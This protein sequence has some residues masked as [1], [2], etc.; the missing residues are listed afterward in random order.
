M[1]SINNIEIERKF[2]VNDSSYKTLA[3]GQVR[4]TQGYLCLNPNCSVRVR[5]W[6]EQAF[7][8]IK[9]KAQANGFSRYE[10]EKEITPQ[11]AEELFQLALP[12]TI[13]KVRWLV[14]IE[15]GLTCEVDEFMGENEGLVMAEVELPSEDMLFTHPAFLGK[16]VTGDVRYYNSYLSQHPFKTW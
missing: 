11:E 9:S 13:D 6:N 15:N 2:L 7:L 8:T 12:G 4:I 10:F 3:T 1:S 5:R 14:P 16:E